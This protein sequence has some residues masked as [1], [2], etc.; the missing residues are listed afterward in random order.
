M[1]DAIA[2]MAP[3]DGLVT[4]AQAGPHFFMP[5]LGQRWAQPSVVGLARLMR[6]VVTH[7]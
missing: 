4:V 1:N 2:Y 3:I 7:R 6:R 5:F